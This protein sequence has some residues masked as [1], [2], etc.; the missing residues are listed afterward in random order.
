MSLFAASL[1][2]TH[3]TPR[4]LAAAPPAQESE[5]FL[6]GGASAAA[7]L[8]ALKE[9]TKLLAAA[10]LP[11]GT[12]AVPAKPAI[13]GSDLKAVRAA[14]RGT[15]VKFEQGLGASYLVGPY[16]TDLDKSGTKVVLSTHGLAAGSVEYT[17]KALNEKKVVAVA[18]GVLQSTEGAGAHAGDL[19]VAGVKV[20]LAADTSTPELGGPR[21]RRH[22]GAPYLHGGAR[23]CVGH[24]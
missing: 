2:P 22:R 24:T 8:A 6:R 18:L 17:L 13:W 15:I 5:S 1:H 19:Q 14:M 20:T 4:S 11:E 12:P 23:R 7:M 10:V 16:D 3:I 9:K 21:G